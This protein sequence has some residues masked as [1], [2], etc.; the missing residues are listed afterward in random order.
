ML[1]TIAAALSALTTALLALTPVSNGI[2]FALLPVRRELG[3]GIPGGCDQLV[4]VRA[5]NGR[6]A[7]YWLHSHPTDVRRYRWDRPDF[8][9]AVYGWDGERLAADCKGR[10]MTR[11]ECARAIV[12]IETRLDW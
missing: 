3:L 4:A 11:E 7:L 6:L 2:T 8:S 12:A 1:N 5:R 9:R 10:W